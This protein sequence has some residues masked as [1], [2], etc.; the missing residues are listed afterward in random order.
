MNLL[1]K[2]ISFIF[3]VT[4]SCCGGD[5]DVSYEG[6]ICPLCLMSFETTEGGGAMHSAYLYKDNLRK[7]I[8]KF[9]YSGKMFLAKDFGA[10]MSEK[11]KK[12]P[13][14]N[15]TD[16]IIPVPLNIIRRI[17]RGYNQ[18]ELL[19]REISKQSSKPVFTNVLYR[20]KMTKP[21]FELSREER[22][23]N[24]K[25][26]FFIKNKDRIFKK[27]VLLIDDIITTGA[28]ISA[29]AGA[30]KRNGA[31]KIYALSLARD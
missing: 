26:S 9:K 15:E 29:C 14:Y 23:D 2:I 21:Q 24:L 6:R 11:F 20:K 31:K 10:Q 18:A 28:T 17:K 13:F 7:L 5:L 4:C 19:S 1:S 27:N 25:R 16:C 30:L 22:F 8:L 12:L 3:P